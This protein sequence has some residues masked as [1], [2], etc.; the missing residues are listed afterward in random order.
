MC[1]D[2][3]DVTSKGVKCQETKN[4]PH[5]YMQITQTAYSP[6][7]GGTSAPFPSLKPELIVSE[8]KLLGDS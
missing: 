4:R 2:K 6:E 1:V 7:D 3:D 8:I 5:Y